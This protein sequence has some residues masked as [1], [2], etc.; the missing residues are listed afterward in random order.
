MI[1][2]YYVYIYLNPLK[3]G[4]YKYGKLNFKYEPFYIGKGI[5]NRYKVH[6]NNSNSQNKLKQNTINKIKKNKQA[7]IIFKLYENLT[8]YSALRLEKELIK[9]IGRK[10]TNTGTLSNMTDGGEGTSGRKHNIESRRKMIKVTNKIVQYDNIGNIIKIWD[11]ILEISIT[12][13]YILTNHLHRACKSNGHRKI[14]DYFWKYYENEKV[15]DKIIIIDKYKPIL[16]YDLDGEF[17]KE[18]KCS[19]DIS[20]NGYSS[21][22][23]LKCCRNN[24]NKNKYY[25]FKNFMWFFKNSNIKIIKPYK[26][27]IAKGY[28]KRNKKEIK[29]YDRNGNYIETTNTDKLMK[30]KYN[31]KTIY[32]CCNGHLKS[33]QDFIW[34]WK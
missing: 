18:W 5:N 14:D 21:S 22:A 29:K 19:S 10:E 31:V 33:T 28:L 7:P 16:Q 32:R 34:K 8:E 26:E 24:S 9:I 4:L 27:N 30:E 20:A 12:Y 2:Q 11:D 25:K 15:T 6:L 23:I 3:E 13:P 17:I 1:P